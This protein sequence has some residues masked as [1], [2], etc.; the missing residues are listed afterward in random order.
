MDNEFNEWWNDF[1]KIQEILKQEK[2]FDI[3][4]DNEKF[5]KDIEKK[6]KSGYSIFDSFSLYIEEWK[7]K[8][9]EKVEFLKLLDTFKNELE[10][11]IVKNASGES[12]KGE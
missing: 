10:I 11:K 8:K 12:I 7:V 3:K 4:L 1:E 2:Y 9:S 5:I 6:L